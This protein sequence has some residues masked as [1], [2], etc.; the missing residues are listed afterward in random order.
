VN[1]GKKEEKFYTPICREPRICTEKEE[2]AEKKKR[3]RGSKP[4]ERGERR[5][6]VLKGD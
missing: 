1:S 2:G 4:K 5:K 3:S 6:P